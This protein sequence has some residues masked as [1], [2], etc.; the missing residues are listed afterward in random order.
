MGRACNTDLITTT[1]PACESNLLFHIVNFDENFSMRKSKDA[2]EVAIG[3]PRY[4]AAVASNETPK[5]PAISSCFCRPVAR[6]N[7]ILLLSGPIF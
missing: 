7:Q 2:L 4:V 6:L 5:I 3:A 1:L